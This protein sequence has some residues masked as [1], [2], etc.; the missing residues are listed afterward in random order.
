MENQLQL[1]IAKLELKQLELIDKL[2]KKNNDYI[3]RLITST[4]TGNLVTVNG[5]WEILTGFDEQSFVGKT[6]LDITPEYDHSLVLNIL[7]KIEGDSDNF[8]TFTS[9]LIRKDGKVIVVNWKGKYFPNINGIVYIGR[10]SK[11]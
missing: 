2:S 9:D 1:T 7:N 3:I 10:V 6:W 8:H 5:D 11:R 4:N